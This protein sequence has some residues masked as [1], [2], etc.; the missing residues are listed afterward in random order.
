MNEAD[1]APKVTAKCKRLS[2]RAYK[3]ALPRIWSKGRRLTSF[4]E[5]VF[6]TKQFTTGTLDSYS[7]SS[8]V[9]LAWDSRV[10]Q[11]ARN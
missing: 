11:T 4:F 9:H 10:R 5:I 2:I 1:L 6:L 7:S 8:Q 3:L